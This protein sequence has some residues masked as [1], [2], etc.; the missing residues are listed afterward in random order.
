MDENEEQPQESRFEKNKQSSN[1]I[2]GSLVL[3]FMAITSLYL[4]EKTA[5]NFNKEID[6]LQA[7]ATLI[8]GEIKPR[9]RVID[10]IF[11]IESDGLILKREVIIYQWKEYTHK[12]NSSHQILLYDYKKGWSQFYDNSSSFNEPQGHYNPP[13]KYETELFVTDATID[14][15][16]IDKTV[17][18]QIDNFK[19]FHNKKGV[20]SLYIGK[21]SNHPSVGDLKIIYSFVPATTYTILGKLQNQNIIPFQTTDGNN[22]IFLHEGKIDKKTILQEKIDTDNSFTWIFRAIGLLL[23]IFGIIG[24]VTRVQKR[25]K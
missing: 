14:K 20:N 12:S 4:N 22:F 8:Q 21:D 9:H 17:I 18:K 16:Y 5:I 15:Y 2:F 1:S 7:D 23:F 13:P 24:L 11:H 3:L 19:K 10:P 25:K 6:E